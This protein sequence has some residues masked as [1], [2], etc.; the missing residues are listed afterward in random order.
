VFR[1][2]QEAFTNVARHSNANRVTLSLTRDGAGLQLIVADNGVARRG[3]HFVAGV[4]L[5][6]MDARVRRFGGE[7]KVT[8]EDMGVTIGATFPESG[9]AASA[10]EPRPAAAPGPVWP[11]FQP[12]S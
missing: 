3:Q 2:V 10:A 8:V 4:G 9:I 11:P 5:T 6:G 1:I 7:L 12:S